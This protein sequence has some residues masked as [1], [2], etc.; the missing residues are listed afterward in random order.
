[1][2][3]QW[4]TTLSECQRNSILVG[5]YYTSMTSLQRFTSKLTSWY[6]VCPKDLNI[7]F[8]YLTTRSSMLAGLCIYTDRLFS[9]GISITKISRSW[10]CLA[11]IKVITLLVKRQ[12]YI[13]TALTFSRSHPRFLI[14]TWFIRHSIETMFYMNNNYQIKL[15]FCTF[16]FSWHLEI[17]N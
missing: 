5:M 16:M 15:K 11:F 13:E 12:L 17:V 6:R 3:T 2:A 1:M 14:R 7:S 4:F 8:F 9:C 10:D